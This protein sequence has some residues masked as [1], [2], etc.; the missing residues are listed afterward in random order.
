[1]MIFVISFFSISP[2]HIWRR[3]PYVIKDDSGG[4]LKRTLKQ[5][6]QPGTN[7]GQM[8]KLS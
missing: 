4:G 6:N 1:M 7:P 5:L 8:E 2:L 3:L